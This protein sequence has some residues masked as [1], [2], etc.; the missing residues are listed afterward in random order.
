MEQV[1]M[2]LVSVSF[3]HLSMKWITQSEDTAY[4]QERRSDAEMFRL[5]DITRFQVVL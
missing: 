4:L 5:S 1:N 2:F 3:K